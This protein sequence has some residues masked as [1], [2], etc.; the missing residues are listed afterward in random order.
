MAKVKTTVY[1]DEDVLRQVRVSAARQGKRDS[2]VIEE[3][4]RSQTIGGILDSIY[5]YQREQGIEPLGEEEAM[6]LAYRE[7]KA[8]RAE[9]G[10]SGAA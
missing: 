8:M 7:L 2:E 5:E 9:G 6:E 4:L 3:A 10:R 1:I